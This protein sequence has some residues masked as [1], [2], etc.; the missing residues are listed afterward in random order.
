M[1][2]LST[3]LVPDELKR[4]RKLALYAEHSLTTRQAWSLWS[5]VGGSSVESQVSMAIEV[6]W[7]QPAPRRPGLQQHV[8]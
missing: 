6:E 2:A 8:S 7:R 5:R 3:G 4:E 1:F